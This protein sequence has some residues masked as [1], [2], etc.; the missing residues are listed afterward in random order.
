MPSILRTELNKP[1]YSG[2]SHDD[3][4]AALNARNKR[5][6]I[7]SEDVKRYLHLASKWAGI[8]AASLGLFGASETKRAT[9]LN[10]IDA[11]ETFVTFDLEVSA[12]ETAINAQLDACITAELIAANDKT[13]ILALADNRRTQGEKLGLGVVKVGHVIAARAE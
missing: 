6:P 11:L 9:A 3:A 4:A 1:E 13:A 8:R 10:L 5:G 7:P 12:Y 2:T